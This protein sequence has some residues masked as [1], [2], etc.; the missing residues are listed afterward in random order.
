MSFKKTSYRVGQN[1]S[2]DS[3]YRSPD[4]TPCDHFFWVM[5][6]T[7]QDE[8]KNHRI[9]TAMESITKDA[10]KSMDVMNLTTD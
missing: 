1:D 4:L 9:T 5:S 6:S 10:A 2:F 8:L 7:H 3:S